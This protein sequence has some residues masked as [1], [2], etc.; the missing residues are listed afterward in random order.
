[1]FVEHGAHLP[2][3]ETE[4]AC[5]QPGGAV[6]DDPADGTAYPHRDTEFTVN[7]HTSGR[8]RSGTTRTSV[9]EPE[10]RAVRVTADGR[11]RPALEVH[12]QFGTVAFRSTPVSLLALPRRSRSVQ[13]IWC[14]L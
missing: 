5:A 12:S 13:T 2:A 4:S 14:P 9:P 7:V 6:D 8:T 11:L 1:M 10:R 3:P